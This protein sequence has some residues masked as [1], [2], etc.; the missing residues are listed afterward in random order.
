MLERMHE[1]PNLIFEPAP[2]QP[3]GEWSQRRVKDF[4]SDSWSSLA[5]MVAGDLVDSDL[6]LSQLD[7]VA[8]AYWHP[9]SGLHLWRSRGFAKLKHPDA[10]VV[11]KPD[12]LRT[13]VMKELVSGMHPTRVKRVKG[14]RSWMAVGPLEHPVAVDDLLRTLSSLSWAE[15][16]SEFKFGDSLVP[17]IRFHL[18]DYRIDAPL[19][20]ANSEAWPLRR[21][22]FDVNRLIRSRDGVKVLNRP[23][24]IEG[25][26]D[27]VMSIRDRVRELDSWWRESSGI[28]DRPLDRFVSW[29]TGAGS[30]MLELINR[31]QV[32]S[33]AHR[34]YS[35]AHVGGYAGF[36]GPGLTHQILESDSGWAVADLGAAYPT[37]ASRIELYRWVDFKPVDDI[38]SLLKGGY[39]AGICLRV[40]GPAESVPMRVGPDDETVCIVMADIDSDLEWDM[41]LGDYLNAEV[42]PEVLGAWEPVIGDSG[43]PDPFSMMLERKKL[44]IDPL[45]W[46][47]VANSSYG[48]LARRSGPD[49]LIGGKSMRMPLAASI[50]DYVRHYTRRIVNECEGIYTDTDS[51]IIPYHNWDKAFAIACEGGFVLNDKCELPSEFAVKVLSV[52]AKRYALK[53]IDGD[54]VGRCHGL[55]QWFF[56]DLGSRTV[57]SVAWSD[58]ALLALWQMIFPDELGEASDEWATMPLFN[59]FVVKTKSFQARLEMFLME[60]EGYDPVQVMDYC[61]LGTE[62][63][64]CELEDGA[65]WYSFDV[66]QVRHLA[67]MNLSDLAWLWGERYDLKWDYSNNSRWCFGEDSVIVGHPFRRDEDV[68][69]PS[70]MDVDK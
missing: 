3:E 16:I 70:L 14:G 13:V 55:G 39:R 23:N 62:G 48:V 24:T 43:N 19:L 47:G 58:D 68:G 35:H 25:L 12:R 64:F 30:M 11:S 31:V 65:G 49:R 50:T 57:K 63:Y 29:G 9:V 2:S 8:V 32:S 51:A 46:R 22:F 1:R 42:K 60:R 28:E 54:F 15:P 33:E 7:P 17:A 18:P 56:Y 4:D 53:G 41:M 34:A 40:R 66:E 6:S 27:K 21:G 59:R 69:D 20:G 5:V 37:A 38:V 44:G 36:T 61:R 67:V 52:G 26:I 45:W 10:K